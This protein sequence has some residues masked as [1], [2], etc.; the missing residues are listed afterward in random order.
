MRP[1]RTG[2]AI[3]LFDRG[4]IGAAAVRREAGYE[5]S[6]APDTPPLPP[7]AEPAGGAS[8]GEDGAPP[9]EV[10]PPAVVAAGIGYRRG[11]GA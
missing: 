2:E 11:A 9:L 10:G 6:D 4:I 1:N 3:D 5:E 8:S 7:G